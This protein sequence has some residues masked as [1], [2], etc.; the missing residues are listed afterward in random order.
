MRERRGVHRLLARYGERSSNPKDNSYGA[1][2]MCVYVCRRVSCLL[3]RETLEA[4]APLLA[5]GRLFTHECISQQNRSSSD[6]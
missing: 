1:I 2:R 5:H 3:G 4:T 6:A